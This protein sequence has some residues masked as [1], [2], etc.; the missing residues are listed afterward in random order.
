M[1]TYYD[2]L[3]LSPSAKKRQIKTAYHNL[4]KKYHPDHNPDP[5]AGAV[6]AKLNEAYSTL[7]DDQKRS[8]YDAF[9]RATAETSSTSE[10]TRKPAEAIPDI[11][12]EK[13]RKMDATIRLSLMY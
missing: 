10:R 11:V 3:G 6:T 5:T 2:I 9:L 12:C 1:P 4:L 7:A 8:A 13:C